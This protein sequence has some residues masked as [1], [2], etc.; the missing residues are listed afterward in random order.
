[1]VGAISAVSATARYLRLARHLDK[2][3]YESSIFGP[4]FVGV[5][6]MAAAIFG[7]CSFSVDN[8]PESQPEEIATRTPSA[9]SSMKITT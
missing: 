3:K 1:M 9:D 2:G 4:V 7:V 8:R 6:T 5:V